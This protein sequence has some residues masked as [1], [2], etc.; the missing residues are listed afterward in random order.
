MTIYSQASNAV[1][2]AATQLSDNLV[3]NGKAVSA[4]ADEQWTKAGQTVTWAYDSVNQ[5]A[6]YVGDI[7]VSASRQ[8]ADQF[9]G[10]V[11]KYGVQIGKLVTLLD[12]YGD[13]A[14]SIL[15]AIVSNPGQFLTNLGNSLGQ[16][17]TNFFNGLPTTLPGQVLQ[18]ITGNGGL[19][20]VPSLQIDWTKSAQVGQW[21][22]NVLHLTW[23]D[24]QGVLINKLGAGNVA[25]ISQ[26]YT[27]L[28]SNL[29]DGDAGI[30]NW[31]KQAGTGMTADQ[32]I[33]KVKS[34]A[35]DFVTT[36][37]VPKIVQTIA[38]KF[39]PGANVLTTV[40]NTL[41]WVSQNLEQFQG[42]LGLGGTILNGWRPA[43]AAFMRPIGPAFR[44]LAHKSRF[45][46]C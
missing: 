2:Y 31:L 16:G 42:L 44:D 33:D 34:T 24:I 36:N 7:V 26:A 30:F 14:A 28:Q 37:V 45:C 3:I 39:I 32:L 23:D 4:W 43:N 6:L 12:Q 20:G 9:M 19:A 25:L 13:A 10:L 40:Y 38:A 1:N 22:L 11:E 21:L 17:I 46:S 8:T 29:S 27:E 15:E 35:V 5:A 41:Q 18:W